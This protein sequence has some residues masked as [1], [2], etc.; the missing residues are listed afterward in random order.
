[1]FSIGRRKNSGSSVSKF[2]NNPRY[3]E[4]GRVRADAPC[5]ASTSRGPVIMLFAVLIVGA[6]LS[7]IGYLDK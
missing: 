4:L 6:I 3:V 2:S 5:E 7:L 1:M